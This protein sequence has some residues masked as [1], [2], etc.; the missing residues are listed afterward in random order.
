MPLFVIFVFGAVILGAG[1]MLSPAFPTRQP[2][3]GLASAFALAIIVGGTIF[4][5]MLFGWDILVID[6]LLFALVVGIFLGGTLSIGQARAEARGEV[7]EDQDQ[8]WPGPQ[9]LAMIGVFALVFILPVLILPVPLGA[10]GQLEGYLALAVREGQTLDTLA[11]FLPDVTYVHAPGFSALIA[12]LSQQ[13]GQ[14]IHIVVFVVGGVLGLVCVWLAYDLGGEQQDKR[15]GR[16]H[17]LAILLSPGVLGAYL[18]GYGTGLMGLVFTMAFVIFALRYMRSGYPVDVFLAGLMLGAVIVSDLNLLIV[19]LLGYIPWLATMW[20]GEPKPDPQRWLVLALGVPL[21]AVLAT[22]PWLLNTDFGILFDA[23][24]FERDAVANLTILIQYHGYWIFFVAILGAWLGWLRR[25]PLAIMAIGWL[26]FVFDFS[27]TGG[28]TGLLPFLTQIADPAY[29]AR[30]GP[31]IPYTILGGMALLWVWN[32]YIAPRTGSLSYRQTYGLAGLLLIVVGGVALIAPSLRNV[33]FSFDPAYAS[34]DDLAAMTWLNDNTEPD[35][36]RVLNFYD[37]ADWVP[38]VSNR[39]SVYYPALPTQRREETPE[40]SALAAFWRD[41]TE[42][43]NRLRDA[44]ITH[45]I[46]PQA[47]V[48]PTADLWRF[49]AEIEFTLT[50]SLD[51]VDYLERVFVQN[52]AAVYALRDN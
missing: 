32:D 18:D 29:V 16:A 40:Q 34:A 46:V 9:D 21:V 27:V 10:Q 35:S 2:R 11:P 17:A 49:G 51:E 5:A 28:I 42:S 33:D 44:G 50:V 7:L 52:G 24:N 36:T 8:G 38:V 45:I 25:D 22:S 26:F 23:P 4:Y 12:Y 31:I 43:E 47:L 14:G 13:L 48:E 41:P 39:D 20:L 15:L 3:I 1:V 19:A 37:E 30:F 6:Y